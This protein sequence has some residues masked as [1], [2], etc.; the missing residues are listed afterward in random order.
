MTD[1]YTVDLT[2]VIANTQ[3]ISRLEDR[4][5]QL[6]WQIEMLTQK[7]ADMHDDPLIKWLQ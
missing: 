4:V 2:D 3:H 6:E 1:K 7:L 5:A